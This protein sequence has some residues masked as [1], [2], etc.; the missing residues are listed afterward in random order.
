MR[1]RST[2]MNETI[3]EVVLTIEIVK[4]VQ[5]S[6]PS[7]GDACVAARKRLMLDYDEENIAHIDVL[8][9]RAVPSTYNLSTE[10]EHALV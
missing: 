4:T 2:M 8:D 10:I 3:Y 1:E 7:M 9:V 6:A 5:L